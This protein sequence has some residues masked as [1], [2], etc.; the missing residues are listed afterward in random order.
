MAANIRTVRSGAPA[1]LNSTFDFSTTPAALKS[2][3]EIHFLK[4][5]ADYPDIFTVYMANSANARD[6][7][8]KADFPNVTEPTTDAALG[9]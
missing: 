3:A 5:S 4:N 2:R 1:C 7:Q 9:D 6:R 8:V